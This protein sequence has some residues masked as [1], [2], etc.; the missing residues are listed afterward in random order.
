MIHNFVAIKEARLGTPQNNEECLLMTCQL[1]HIMEERRNV[2]LVFT[3]NDNDLHFFNGSSK[4]VTWYIMTKARRAA[5]SIR[6]FSQE[7]NSIMKL[8][9]WVLQNIKNSNERYR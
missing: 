7:M 9:S 2:N 8:E 6:M 4:I 5:I 3:L 1:I